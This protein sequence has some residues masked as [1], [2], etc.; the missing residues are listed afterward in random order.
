M[1]G[2]GGLGVVTKITLKTEPAYE[3]RQDLYENLPLS[4][5]ED[6]FDEILSSAYSV[7]LFTDWQKENFN[8]VW[9]K[10]RVADDASVALEAEWYRATLATGHLHPIGEMPADNCTEQMGIHGPWHERL[11]HFR[12]DFT[13]SAGEEL[14]SEYFVPP[15]ACL[16]G[17]PRH[18]SNG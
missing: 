1:V 10:R 9:L 7:S 8:Q 3:M 17:D 4:Q 2:L 16:R 11:P 18:R 15:A 5:L 14:Q 12:L 13:P 6:H